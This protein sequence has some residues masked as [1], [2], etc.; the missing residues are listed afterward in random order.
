MSDPSSH[1]MKSP[2]SPKEDL[3]KPHLIVDTRCVACMLLLSHAYA[4]PLQSEMVW[5][6][7]F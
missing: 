4:T 5:N 3:K 7:D 2:K 1:P 6:G